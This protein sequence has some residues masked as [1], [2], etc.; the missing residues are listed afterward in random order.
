MAVLARRRRVQV[1]HVSRMAVFGPA[2][3]AP[4]AGWAYL[5]EP[6]DVTWPHA[7]L[8]HLTGLAAFMLAG[9]L[10]IPGV[11]VSLTCFLPD[12]PKMLV[13][14]SWRAGYRY[15]H[16]REGARSSRIS[17]RLRRLIYIADGYCCINCGSRADLQ[18][19]HRVP[20][21]W[22]GLTILWN[23]FTLC[24][25]CNVRKLDYHEVHGRPRFSRHF[26]TQNTEL[27]HHIFRLES[28]RRWNPFR[29]FRIAWALAA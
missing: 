15:R 23:L 8:W 22:G 29:M 13:R 9:L 26:N 11:L 3:A 14:Q 7:A 1:R 28:R 6:P 24:E 10:V 19:D 16:G 5:H 18:I 25:P 12:L 17:A 27:A 21:A 4:L 2:F 20:W